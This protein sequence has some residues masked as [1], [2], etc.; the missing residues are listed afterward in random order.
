M[1]TGVNYGAKSGQ[2]VKLPIR[3]HLVSRLWVSGAMLLLP[4]HAFIVWIGTN[5]LLLFRNTWRIRSVSSDKRNKFGEHKRLT[6]CGKAETLCKTV[7]V[8]HT[9]SRLQTYQ[10][11][12]LQVC[13]VNVT[14][15]WS[16]VR[17]GHVAT[18]CFNSTAWERQRITCQK[19]QSVNRDSNCALTSATSV[20]CRHTDVD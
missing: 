14:A 9:S 1:I 4:L 16:R 18:A 19:S 10:L 13:N 17:T 11:H 2:G 3:L 5:L 12:K 8:V 15:R 7:V 6:A 20:P